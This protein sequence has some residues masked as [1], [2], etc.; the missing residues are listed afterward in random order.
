MAWTGIE[1]L[2]EIKSTEKKC[3]SV[4]LLKLDDFRHKI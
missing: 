3:S 2:I 4:A 1:L